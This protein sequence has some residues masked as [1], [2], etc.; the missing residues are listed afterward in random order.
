M[1]TLIPS[2][3]ARGLVFSGTGFCASPTNGKP[4]ASENKNVEIIW[5]AMLRKRRAGNSIGLLREER[6]ESR[7][8]EPKQTL[9]E[10]KHESPETHF[11]NPALNF[12]GYSELRSLKDT[13]TIKNRQAKGL[14]NGD[15]RLPIGS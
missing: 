3:R 13:M 14:P 15:F 7:H 8:G 1:P 5:W 10:E 6:N 9:D 2:S 11:P 12:H 4:G